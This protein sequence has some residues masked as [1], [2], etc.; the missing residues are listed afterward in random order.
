VIQ[1]ARI[2]KTKMFFEQRE[3]FMA[4]LEAD[5]KLG[6]KQAEKK[7]LIPAFRLNGTSDLA[8]EKYGIIQKFPDVQFYDYTKVLG[9]KTGDLKNYHL[10]FSNADGNIND[11]L[12]AKQAGLNIAVVFKKELP[13]KHLGLKVING[14]DTDLRFLDEKKVIVVSLAW[15]P[16][17]KQRKTRQVL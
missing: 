13:E 7:G 1:Q 11:V 3:E 15:L 12:A 8:W 9:R 4:A 16:K 6:I 17:V 10:T 2:R 14:D 5:I